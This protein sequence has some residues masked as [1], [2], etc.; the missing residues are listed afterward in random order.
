MKRLMG[1]TLEDDIETT[2]RQIVENMAISLGINM[3]DPNDQIAKLV[4]I[5]IKDADPGR[6]LK[7]CHHIFISLGPNPPLSAK[8]ILAHTLGLPSV[9]SKIIHCDL[10]KHFYVEATLDSAYAAFKERYCDRCAD[11]APRA[12]DWEYSDQWQQQ[13]NLRHVEFMEDFS[14]GKGTKA[15]H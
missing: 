6:V 11:S 12:P 13:E 9:G 10:H 2:T 8:G 15:Q 5:G 7:N 3:S 14:G 4:E 1:E